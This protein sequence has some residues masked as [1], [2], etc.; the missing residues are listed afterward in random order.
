LHIPS[1]AIRRDALTA[2]T[3]KRP[4]LDGAALFSALP[5]RR[6]ISLLRALVS[7]E[8]I[9]EFLDNVNEQFA[10]IGLENARQLHLALVEAVDIDSPISDYYSHMRT[11]DDGGFLRGLVHAC[12]A[13]CGRLAG[14]HAVRP[15]IVREAKRAS[16]L[17]LNHEPNPKRRNDL[18]RE[19]ASLQFGDESGY[20]WFEL[21]GAATSSLTVHML[22]SQAAEPPADHHY[23]EQAYLAYFPGVAL[24]ST[25]L[26]SYIEDAAD[27][28]AQ[29][30]SY[31]SHYEGDRQAVERLRHLIHTSL[32][33]AHN[34]R[35]GHRHSVV[36][37]AM[38]ALYLTDDN[39]RLNSRCSHTVQLERAGGLLTRLLIPILRLWRIM[40]GLRTA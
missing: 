37:A 33:S 24:L 10:D 18:L 36:V 26:D 5:A 23:T 40:Y 25:M 8:I 12:R 28:T 2:L 14:Y 38:I 3:R 30:H 39:A 29:H 21:T 22:L 17:A 7:Y 19:W 27:A 6:H 32:A 34:L 31:I 4:H 35:R 9:L 13:S 1:E 11:H 16:V 15:R 20:S